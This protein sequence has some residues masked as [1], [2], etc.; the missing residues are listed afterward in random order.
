MDGEV[1]GGWGEE[2]VGNGKGGKEGGYERRVRR[3]DI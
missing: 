3:R 2:G 1:V